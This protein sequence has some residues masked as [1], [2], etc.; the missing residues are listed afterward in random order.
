VLRH[1]PGA[2]TI[3]DTRWIH[4][5]PAAMAAAIGELAGPDEWRQAGDAAHAQ[6]AAGFNLPL[7][8]EA[9][10]GLLTGDLHPA[11]RGPVLEL[12]GSG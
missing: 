6:A 8:C 3:Y 11:A 7:V 4:Q 9:W 1:W 12:L 5:D 2:E 10:R